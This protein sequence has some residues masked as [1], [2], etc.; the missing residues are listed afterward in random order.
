MVML[1]LGY[2]PQRL[3]YSGI[4]AL[5]Q[6]F[7]LLS[8]R[9][10]KYALNFLRQ[11]FPEGKTDKELLAI[12]RRSTG[13]FLRV[14]IDMMRV[15]RVLRKGNIE[16][17]IEGV[18]SIREQLGEGPVLVVTGHLGSWEVGAIQIAGIREAHA[19]AR[20]FKNPLLH[21]YMAN[22]RKAGG[23]HLHSRR[24]GLRGLSRALK[25]G[26]VGMQ[27]V[28]QNQ[29]LRGVFVPFFGKQASTER[30]AATLAVRKGYPV[31]ICTCVRKGFGFQF[32]VHVE[33]M[34][35]PESVAAHGDVAAAV[36]RLVLRINQRLEK[37]ILRHPEQYLWAHDRYRTQPDENQLTDESS[38]V[39]LRGGSAADSRP[40]DS[41]AV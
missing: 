5:G 40:L 17:Y 24:G 1:G 22:S 25:E 31:A 9:R 38:A 23:L 30:S 14:T 28:D 19:I 4:A 3:A 2:L 41:E 34:I 13:N 12:G 18:E 10:Q 36:K 29:R 26:A 6:F 8:K 33:E 39:E 15:H 32:H 11:A 37:A 21:R 16:D 7:F 27:V 20:R 35:E